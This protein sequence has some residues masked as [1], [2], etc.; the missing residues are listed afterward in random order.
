M[1]RLDFHSINNT[2]QRI[3]AYNALHFSRFG[4]G[5]KLR[6]LQSGFISFKNDSY[7]QKGT[8]IKDLQYLYEYK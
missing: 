6:F 5:L 2:I 1:E 7:E 4:K 8:V 3:L